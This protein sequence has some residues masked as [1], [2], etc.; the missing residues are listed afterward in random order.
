MTNRQKADTKREREALAEPTT[1]QASV[2]Q[3][4]SES[5]R[6]R[7]WELHLRGVPKT[8]IAEELG[9]HR[10]TVA[11]IINSAYAEI[12]DERKRSNARKL[13]GAIGRMRR[14]QEQAWDDHDADDER[15]RQVLAMSLAQAQNQDGSDSDSDEDGKPKSGRESNVSIKYQS[16]R[17]QYLRIILDAEKEI[18]RLEGVYE[19]LL[20]IDVGV[21]VTFVK[22]TADDVQRDRQTG[23]SGQIVTVA[24]H[25]GIPAPLG[26]PPNGEYD[27]ESGGEA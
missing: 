19:S 10:A 7:A 15:E 1:E 23:Q 24:T 11:R 8:R 22:L 3:H 27:G 14:I 25:R 12:A 9:I 17:S 6:A 20:N 13:D 18:A 21:S 5:S 4:A 26:N 2:Y 16:Q